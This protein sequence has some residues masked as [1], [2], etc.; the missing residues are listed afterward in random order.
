MFYPEDSTK[1]NWDLFITVVLL[2]TCITTP[3]R[4]AFSDGD[5]L[6]QSIVKWFVDFLFLVDIIIIFNSAV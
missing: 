5:T 2:Y 1:A 6:G 4:I 3:M